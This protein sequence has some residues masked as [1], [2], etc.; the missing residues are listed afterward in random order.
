MNMCFF[1]ESVGVK[2]YEY[3]NFGRWLFPQSGWAN[4]DCLQQYMRVLIIPY[5]HQHLNSHPF[6]FSNIK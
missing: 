5:F 4:S 1:G 2:G 6:L 3:L